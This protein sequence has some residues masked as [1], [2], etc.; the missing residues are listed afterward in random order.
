MIRTV[1]YAVVAVLVSGAAIF[2]TTYAVAPTAGRMMEHPW[3]TQ[4]V[5]TPPS[6]DYPGMMQYE[7]DGQ[8]IQGTPDLPTEAYEALPGYP[9]MVAATVF[10]DP[11]NP[12]N[13]TLVNPS[14]PMTTILV[15]IGVSAI[16]VALAMWRLVIA[17]LIFDRFERREEV[18]V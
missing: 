4:A 14:P 12:A 1:L 7:V 5:I 9:D 17:R 10:Y 8:V 16:I 3:S 2:L 11:K 15:S 18:T 13:A 6:A